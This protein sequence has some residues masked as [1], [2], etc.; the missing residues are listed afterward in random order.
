MKKI[1]LS[2]LKKHSPLIDKKLRLP[3][4][5][6]DSYWRRPK[7]PYLIRQLCSS[8][9]IGRLEIFFLGKRSSPQRT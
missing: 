5:V 7:A 3:K 4:A 2:L 9:C 8:W 6:H 1:V